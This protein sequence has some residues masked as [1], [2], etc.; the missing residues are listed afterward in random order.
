MDSAAEERKE[1]V[2]QCMRFVV[3]DHDC[4]PYLDALTHDVLT[5]E[6]LDTHT[7]RL[8]IQVQDLDKFGQRLYP[9]ILH[10]PAPV[11]VA[12]ETAVQQAE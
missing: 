9:R 4:G 5:K 7:L 2:Q 8:I 12:F 10:D 1:L 3:P 6:N 11:I